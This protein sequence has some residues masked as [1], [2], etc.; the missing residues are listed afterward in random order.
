[1][2]R[3]PIVR[4]TSTDFSWKSVHSCEDDD[5]DCKDNNDDTEDEFTPR[6]GCKLPRLRF[7][8][9]VLCDVLDRLSKIFC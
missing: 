4:V 6:D 1:M 2:L 3:L 7:H 9:L 5:D 8:H